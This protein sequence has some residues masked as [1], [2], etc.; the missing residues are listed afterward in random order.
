MRRLFFDARREISRLPQVAPGPD[1]LRRQ[2]RKPDRNDND[3]GPRQ[4]D[5][6]ASPM[7]VT[8]PPTMATPIRLARHPFGAS[9]PSAS[10][11]NNPNPSA[12]EAV[13]LA[14]AT[15]VALSGAGATTR[16]GRADIHDEV[17]VAITRRRRRA[18]AKHHDE[19][20]HEKHIR[21]DQKCDPWVRRTSPAPL[22][23][24][25]ELTPRSWTRRRGRSPRVGHRPI[26]A[27]ARRPR[28][29][30]RSQA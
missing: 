23:P 8:E 14:T 20:R 16:L 29:I 30:R 19:H 3:R 27:S 24:M 11:Q 26:L 4:D 25:P 22:T 6:E 15:L 5:R 17:A 2:D 13:W 9:S 21:D 28:G 18:S 1:E 12:R 10:T 7:R